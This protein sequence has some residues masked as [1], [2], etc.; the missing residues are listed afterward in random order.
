MPRE[1]EREPALQHVHVV[2]RHVVPMPAGRRGHRLQRADVLDA[3]APAGRGGEPEVAVLGV[4]AQAFAVP[5]RVG[6]AHARERGQRGGERARAVVAGR[7][8]TGHRRS[9]VADAWARR[10]ARAGA[11]R[12]PARTR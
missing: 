1:A 3:Q 7:D 9:P 10:T 12:G 4:V 6:G 2:R 11:V 8:V 5:P